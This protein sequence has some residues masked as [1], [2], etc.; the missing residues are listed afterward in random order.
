MV[1]SGGATGSNSNSNSHVNATNETATTGSTTMGA[2]LLGAFRV[3]KLVLHQG[4]REI[5]VRPMLVDAAK[6][7]QMIAE[8]FAHFKPAAS[9]A[10]ASLLPQEQLNQ[11]QQQQQLSMSAST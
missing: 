7:H 1:A 9:A 10:G 2:T 3:L 8:I 5:V 11:Q 4:Q 6:V